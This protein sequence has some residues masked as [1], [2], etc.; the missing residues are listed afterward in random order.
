VF[1]TAI[2]SRW[3]APSEVRALED[4]KPFTE[5]QLAE[6]DRLFGD[7]NPKPAAAPTAAPIGS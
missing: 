6:F 1:Q 2:T 5:S 3:L 4:R 7:A